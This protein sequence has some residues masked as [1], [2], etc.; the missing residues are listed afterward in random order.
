MASKWIEHVKAF[1]KA[2]KM[3]YGCAMA[4]PKCKMSYHK[5]K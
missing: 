5:M 3:T 2:N 1:A 4:D